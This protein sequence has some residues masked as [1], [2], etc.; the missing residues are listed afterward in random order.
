MKYVFFILLLMCTAARADDDLAKYKLGY[1]LFFDPILSEK[2]QVSCAT[3]HKPDHGFSDGKKRAVGQDDRL[4]PF[5]TPTVLN[6]AK[7]PNRSMFWNG[8]RT[9][10]FNQA[11]GPIENPDEMGNQ[12]VGQVAA[13][14]ARLPGYQELF[15][16][17][18]TDG[19]ISSRRML[20]CIVM[21]E[22]QG[23]VA[24]DCL[25]TRH[26]NGEETVL[27]DSAK[28]GAELYIKNCK[29]CHPAPYYTTGRFANTGIEYRSGGNNLGY[30][31]TTNNRE[32]RRMYKIPT[33]LDCTGR[34]PLCHDGSMPNVETLLRHYGVGGKIARTNQAD[35]L[36][37]KDIASIR[38]TEKNVTDLSA[39]LHE[40]LKPLDYPNYIEIPKE[41][42]R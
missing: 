26:M 28:R 21:F 38:L 9:G 41:F 25:A 16:K 35:A 34:Y 15:R 10:L 3:C 13:R 8:R 36:I 40:G 7:I 18:Y 12:T 23:L 31:A 14:I 24:T 27:S 2:G 42:P 4:G 39:F 17:A 29:T 20:E 37:H 32:H 22:E 6:A 5:H 33:L 19:I 11:S 1:L 30:E